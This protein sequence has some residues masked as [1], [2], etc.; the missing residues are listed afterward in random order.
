MHLSLRLIMHLLYYIHTDDDDVAADRRRNVL[1]TD[2]GSAACQGPA[3]R[4]NF[5][6]R[7]E[8]SK[9]LKQGSKS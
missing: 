8:A 2:S 7:R 9:K 5:R 4:R 3:G 1:I 6:T